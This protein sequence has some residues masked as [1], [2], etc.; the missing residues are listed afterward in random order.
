MYVQNERRRHEEYLEL[1]GKEKHI[2]SILSLAFIP[3]KEYQNDSL[4]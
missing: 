1:L 3:Y 2:L 4:N